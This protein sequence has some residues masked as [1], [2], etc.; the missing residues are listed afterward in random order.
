M[1]LK[2]K[3]SNKSSQNLNGQIRASYS[4]I[5]WGWTSKRGKRIIANEI[6][7]RIDRGEESFEEMVI[8]LMILEPIRLME[9]LASQ[10][11]LCFRWIWTRISQV[12]SSRVSQIIELDNSLHIL[13][14]KKNIFDLSDEQVAEEYYLLNRRRTSKHFKWNR[15]KFRQH[16]FK[17][18]F[19]VL[20]FFN[21]DNKN[22]YSNLVEYEI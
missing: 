19:T 8:Y 16:N 1:K 20:W 10:M 13:K 22:L 4:I 2:I 21:L 18:N 14:V 12:E 9:T 11:G 17:W 5:F 15:R 6:V 3:D 7:S